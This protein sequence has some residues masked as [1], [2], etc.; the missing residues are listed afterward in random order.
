ML[1][2]Y[3]CKISSES[4]ATCIV[5]FSILLPGGNSDWQIDKE[6]ENLFISEHGRNEEVGVQNI[7]EEDD[8]R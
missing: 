5:Q 2:S 3:T 8:K 1:V 6:S 7:I 4:L